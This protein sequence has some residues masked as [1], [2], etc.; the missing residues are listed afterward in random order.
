M[1]NYSTPNNQ[2]NSVRA[3]VAG[4]AGTVLAVPLF[5]R[6]KIISRRGLPYSRGGGVWHPR[7][8]AELTIV[9]VVAAV[10]TSMASCSRFVAPEVPPTPHQP[11]TGFAFPKRAFGKKNVVWRSFQRTWFTQWAWL[12]YDKAND[13]AYCH[14]CVTAFKQKKMRS[15]NADPAFVSFIYKD[16]LYDDGIV[17]S[18]AASD[19]QDA[20]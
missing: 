12:H 1:Y 8:G 6:L 17:Q 11:S 3:G 2:C 4:T 13:L 7:G 9:H 14:I 19:L 5:S 10:R 18:V 20:A 15:F 16:M